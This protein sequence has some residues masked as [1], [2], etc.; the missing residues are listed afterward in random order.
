MIMIPIINKV[1]PNIN[2][3]TGTNIKKNSNLTNTLKLS[4]SFSL[5]KLLIS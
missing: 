3:S 2:V 1:T 4:I 5:G